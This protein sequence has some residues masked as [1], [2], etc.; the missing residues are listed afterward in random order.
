MVELSDYVPVN[1]ISLVVLG[2]L[3]LR[4]LVRVEGYH[5]LRV[6]IL[7]VLLWLPTIYLFILSCPTLNY[8][9]APSFDEH[10]VRCIV[11]F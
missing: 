7:T 3:V 5:W 11:E 9:R 1:L 10:G 8:D 2:A 4:K 6:L